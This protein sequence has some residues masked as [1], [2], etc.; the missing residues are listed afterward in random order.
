MEKFDNYLVTE[1]VVP[2]VI[3]LPL[4]PETT[5]MLPGSYTVKHLANGTLIE[6]SDGDDLPFSA[7]L[8]TCAG[9]IPVT[10]FGSKTAGYLVNDPPE[11]GVTIDELD[12]HDRAIVRVE[13]PAA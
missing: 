12:D 5:E 13:K 4:D 8:F 7:T 9:Y 11:P 2:G 6:R 10:F 1:L 3:P